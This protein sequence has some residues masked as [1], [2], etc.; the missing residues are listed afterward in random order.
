MSGGFGPNLK[1]TRGS[2][3]VRV[4]S[5]SVEPDSKP[6]E[7]PL[8]FGAEALAEAGTVDFAG[9]VL[10]LEGDP[11]ADVVLTFVLSRRVIE[12]GGADAM[13]RR[14]DDVDTDDVSKG[15]SIAIVRSS[16]GSAEP[17]A[18]REGLPPRRFFVNFSS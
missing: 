10:G 4:A 9:D 14:E 5:P 3:F 7:V 15:S 8:P 1:I 6:D 13:G 17:E 18:P 16:Q 2:L 12:V 11:A